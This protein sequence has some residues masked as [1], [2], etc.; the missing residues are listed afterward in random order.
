[1]IQGRKRD[2]RPR[3][4]PVGSRLDGAALAWGEGEAVF[5]RSR[6][7]RIAPG[8]VRVR[9]Q[10]LLIL[11][12]VQL[13][14]FFGLWLAVRRVTF[15]LFPQE[16]F[17]SYR[18]IVPLALFFLSYFLLIWRRIYSRDYHYYLRRVHGAILKNA[19][20]PLALACLG[21]LL[22]GT[23]R[24]EPI[25]MTLVFLASGVMSFV[26]ADGCQHLWIRYLSHLGYFRKK[27]LVVGSP[28]AGLSA[29]M[30]AHD[31]GVTKI[32][33]GAIQPSD[34]AWL[35]KPAG[36]GA[37]RVVKDFAEIKTIILRENIGDILLFR[38]GPTDGGFERELVA[39]CRSLPI[40]CSIVPT[41][42]GARWAG[43]TRLIFPNI[44]ASERFAG[45]RD[46]LTSVS[47]KRF[48]DLA[49]SLVCLTLFLPAGLLIALAILFQDGFPVFYVSTRVGKNG[50]PIRFFKF[51]TMIRDAE[52]EKSKLLSF[53][54]RSDGP[55]F[56]M[57]NDPRVTKIGG[58]LRKHSLDEFPQFL[59]VLLGAMSLVGP[60]PHL[61]QEVAEY[62]EADYLRLE[63]MPGI[64]GL[65]QVSGRIATMGFREW[66]DLDLTYRRGW[67]IGLDMEIIAKTISIFFRGLFSR[68][69]PDHY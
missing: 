45:P 25:L 20:L 63:C 38:G 48:V 19:S 27:V 3:L 60:R 54:A 41:E 34:G 42:A 51:R 12:P 39:F 59:N 9:K 11:L 46:S 18:L 8:R 10:K 40:S 30:H 67:S 1:M 62:R 64:V 29:D 17:L 13:A 31:F 68:C 44:S 52:K 55:L 32:F 56:K 14:F 33:A 65:P 57:K 36:D 7:A 50:K 61:P 58:V 47:A 6:S 53:N 43:I 15:Q 66:V 69:G 28:G 35:W 4:A 22:L 37:G 21:F 24:V 5:A 23:W 16:D 26:I 2:A 49:V